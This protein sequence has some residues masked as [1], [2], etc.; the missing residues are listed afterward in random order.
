MATLQPDYPLVS[1][2]T[3]NGTRSLFEALF[4]SNGP[5]P[6]QQSVLSNLTNEDYNAIRAT[7]RSIND[8]LTER[9]L[10]LPPGA[11]PRWRN[12]R[13]M[14]AKCDEHACV[15]TADTTTFIKACEDCASGWGGVRLVCAAC[16]HNNHWNPPAAVPGAPSRHN[17]WMRAISFSKA[18]VCPKC[19]REQHR[20]HPQ[21]F[22]GCTCFRD[23]Y[24]S[25]WICNND[26]ITRCSKFTIGSG[27]RARV[28]QEG[29]RCTNF[30][31][32]FVSGRWHPKPSCLCLRR[33]IPPV[34][35]ATPRDTQQCRM[36]FKF[37]VPT[38][39]QSERVRRTR[40]GNTSVPSHQMLATH[41][42]GKIATQRVNRHGFND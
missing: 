34:R 26:D 42:R 31:P 10:H 9:A 23:R 14:M 33:Y 15:G 2:L 21:G 29:W 36:C 11:T 37:I 19:D 7:K 1:R 32:Y 3:D 28:I 30:G 41:G 22:D 27:F 35:S 5:F 12:Q 16:R 24:S 20:S 40:G 39:R 8:Q 13:Y 6:V 25:V 38:L 18:R 4:D 17:L